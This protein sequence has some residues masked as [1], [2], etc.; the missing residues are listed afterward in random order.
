MWKRKKECYQQV[1]LLL[2][3][4]L[5]KRNAHRTFCFLPFC[6]EEHRTGQLYHGFWSVWDCTAL[7]LIIYFLR[8]RPRKYTIALGQY[9]SYKLQKPWYNYYMYSAC[10]TW[11]WEVLNSFFAAWASCMGRKLVAFWTTPLTLFP[12]HS[13]STWPPH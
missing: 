1:L 6:C 11:V 7:R 10:T 12:S 2:Y 8:L 13:A 3:K 5:G 4:K 9:K